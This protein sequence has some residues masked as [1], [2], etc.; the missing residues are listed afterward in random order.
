MRALCPWTAM[1]LNNS[2]T[3]EM[4]I[5]SH[6]FEEKSKTEAQGPRGARGYTPKD[7]ELFQAS[8]FQMWSTF[9]GYDKITTAPT[10]Q[11]LPQWKIKPETMAKLQRG[12]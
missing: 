7:L 12:F 9:K 3:M 4:F 11:Y 6:K 1:R 8:K 5:N 10:H 2:R